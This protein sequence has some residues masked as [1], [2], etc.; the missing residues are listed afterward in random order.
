MPRIRYGIRQQPR[1][2]PLVVLLAAAVATVTPAPAP[3][4]TA[5]DA[6]ASHRRSKPYCRAGTKKPPGCIP[7]PKEARRRGSID[8]QDQPTRGSAGVVNTGGVGGDGDTRE[9]GALEW[10]SG[11]YGSRAW[12]FRSE[13]FVEA[14]YAEDGKR[15]FT[16]PRVAIRK[17]RLRRGSPK[18]APKGTLMLFEADRINRGLGHVGLSLGGGRMLSALD[19]VRDTDVA[20]SAYWRHIYVGWAPAP[21]R[22]LGRLPLPPGLAPATSGETPVDILAP[23]IDAVVSGTVRLEASAAAGPIAFSAFYS[24][25]PGRGVTPDWDAIGRATDIGG[26]IYVLDWDTRAVADQGSRALGTL[27]IAAFVVDDDGT[28]RGVGSYRRVTVRNAV[29]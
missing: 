6:G 29:P 1:S 2:T 22:W 14:A 11:F 28:P 20:N 17:L 23:T 26:G 5:G 13:R 24:S 7:V 16:S 12:A 18:L 9:V 4:P 3:S 8:P 25:D 27:T 10:A 21:S 19:E 15:G